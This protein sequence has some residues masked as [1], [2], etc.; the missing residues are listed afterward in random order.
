MCD[1]SFRRKGMKAG[2]VG[3]RP[4][5]EEPDAKEHPMVTLR[6]CLCFWIVWSWTEH[7]GSVI[8][9]RLGD[10]TELG[11][12]REELCTRSHPR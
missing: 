8:G 7:V 12:A 2:R 10:S 4:V 6:A 5:G 3:G 11:S 9:A 1:D